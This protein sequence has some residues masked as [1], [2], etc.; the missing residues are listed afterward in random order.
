MASAHNR[1]AVTLSVLEAFY[2]VVQPLRTYL[3]EILDIRDTPL[4][5]IL[6]PLPNEP[7][8]YNTL[9]DTTFVALRTQ[10]GVWDKNT[11]QIHPPVMHM[12]DVS[13]SRCLT[14]RLSLHLLKQHVK[15]IERA[16]TMLLTQRSA[17]RGN[18][19]TAGYSL[20]SHN[21]PP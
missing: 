10:C 21:L 16:Q 17:K 5:S 14:L 8:E 4:R 13:L 1:P 19:I 20:V 9:I 3:N 15:V 6:M 2:N 7:E 11:F 18:I 12:E